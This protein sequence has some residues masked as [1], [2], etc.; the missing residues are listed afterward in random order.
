[1]V[2]EIERILEGC[3]NV[4][5][6]DVE[7]NQNKSTYIVDIVYINPQD[8]SDMT[9]LLNLK[10]KIRQVVNRGFKIK[11]QIEFNC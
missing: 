8:S 3:V 1:M 10:N 7:T 9:M 4:T 11:F 2:K 6:Y 5:S